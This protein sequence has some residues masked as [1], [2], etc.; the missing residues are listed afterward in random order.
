MA[1]KKGAKKPSAVSNEAIHS[2]EENSDAVG[3]SGYVVG[4]DVIFRFPMG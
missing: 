3:A 1:A 2:D 4:C